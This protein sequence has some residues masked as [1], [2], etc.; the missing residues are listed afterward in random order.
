MRC[1]QHLHARRL[2]SSGGVDDEPDKHLPF[3]AGVAQ[4]LRVARL[5]RGDEAH[6]QLAAGPRRRLVL[7]GT[8]QD[9]KWPAGARG[10]RPRTECRLHGRRLSAERDRGK[11]FGREVRDR[12]AGQH[13]RL[14]PRRRTPARGWR[15]IG[16]RRG[17]RRQM[18]GDHR[19]LWPVRRSPNLAHRS[20]THRAEDCEMGRDAQRGAAK[21]PLA[22]RVR[23]EKHSQH[24]S[25]RFV[26]ERRSGLRALDATI[27]PTGE[28]QVAPR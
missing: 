24:D 11:R 10:C 17:V 27:A 4:R 2:D 3:D 16:R 1:R 25:S 7:A 12:D 20:C 22:A 26:E 6:H 28:G 21:A 9:A 8:I 15:V 23:F 19:R 14:R 5:G 13:R 18:K